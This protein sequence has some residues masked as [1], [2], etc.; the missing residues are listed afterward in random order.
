VPVIV[1]SAHQD[2]KLIQRAETDHIMAYA[3]KPVK[4][5]DLAPA[6]AL[7]RH[8]FEQFNALRHEPLIYAKRWRTAKRSSVRKAL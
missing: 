3:I 6:I 1:V 2:A 7:T 4:Q 8:R 5:S